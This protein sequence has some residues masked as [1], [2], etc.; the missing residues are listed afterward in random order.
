[1]E[2]ERKFRE[3]IAECKKGVQLSDNNPNFIADLGYAY[4]TAGHRAQ[5]LKILQDLQK[6]SRNRYVAPYQV[7][8]IYAALGEKRRALDALDQA[9]KERSPW[10]NNLYVDSRF[11]GL[12]SESAFVNLLKGAGFPNDREG[13]P[14]EN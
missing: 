4:A 14:A 1:D 11:D 5:A 6:L 7:A 2:E 9:Y 10:I 3:A 8:A 12:R 13:H